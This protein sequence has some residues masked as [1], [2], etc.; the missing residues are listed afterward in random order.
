MILCDVDPAVTY[1]FFQ[2]LHLLLRL[3][4]LLKQLGKQNRVQNAEKQAAVY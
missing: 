2:I 1:L 3:V 4:Y